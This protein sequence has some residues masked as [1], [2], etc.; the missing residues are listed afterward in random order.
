MLLIELELPDVQSRS[1]I[2][3]SLPRVSNCIAVVTLY[4]GYSDPNAK[5]IRKLTLTV[6]ILW[7]PIGVQPAKFQL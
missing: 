6:V 3:H 5:T 4:Y 7:N 1:C 2:E